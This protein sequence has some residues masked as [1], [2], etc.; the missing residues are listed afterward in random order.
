MISDGFEWDDDKADWNERKHRV[1]FEA[2]EEV[3]DDPLHATMPDS[4]HSSDE[5]R[6]ITIGERWNEIL[7]VAHAERHGRIRIISARRATRTEKRDYMDKNLD[8]INDVDDLQPEYNFKGAVR[9]KYHRP[10]KS[11]IRMTIDEDVARHYSSSELVN[12]ALRQLIA[13]GRAP[14]PRNE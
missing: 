1:S 12:A 11:T 7:V 14:E 5:D 13:E 10:G 2:A 4:L 6:F 9:G 8:T 3:F